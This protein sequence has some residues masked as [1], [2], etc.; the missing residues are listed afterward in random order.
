MVASILAGRM[1]YGWDLEPEEYYLYVPDGADEAVGV[2]ELEMPTRDNRHLVWAGV[3][4]HPDHRRRGH[5]T[6][7]HG[8]GAV[9]GRPGG[10][11]HDL[12]RRGRR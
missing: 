7:D 12:G 5:G 9:P 4:V 11:R 10:A 1:R 8:R 6:V 3:T 2:L